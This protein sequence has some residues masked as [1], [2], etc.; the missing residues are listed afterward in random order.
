M[1]DGLPIAVVALGAD[2][3]A[4]LVKGDHEDL[5]SGEDFAA[6]ADGVVISDA[7]GGSFADGSVDA[8][9]AFL[10]LAIGF[11]AGKFGAGGNEFIE[12]NFFHRGSDYEWRQKSG[13]FAA[14]PEGVAWGSA[15]NVFKSRKGN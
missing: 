15:R 3:A 10:N 2:H 4:R 12:A 8:H 1:I 11:P 6:E 7:D 13:T 5:A 14:K 9:F